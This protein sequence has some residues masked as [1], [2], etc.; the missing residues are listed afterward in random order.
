M[1]TPREKSE[2]KANKNKTPNKTMNSTTN[3]TETSRGRLCDHVDGDIAAQEER[4]VSCPEACSINSMK[5]PGGSS[6]EGL[7]DLI[8]HKTLTNPG[9][10]VAVDSPAQGDTRE[11]S[12]IRRKIQD[13][14]K[15]KK[16][17]WS[18]IGKK[19]GI[20][21]AT[22]NMKGR[23]D[24]RKR[25]K[26]PMV[27][28]RMRKERILVLGLQETHLNEEEAEKL[29]NACPKLIVLSNGKSKNKEGVAF[30][31][32]KDMVKGMQWTHDVLIEGRASKLEIKV[33]DERTMVIILLYA[34]NPE[35]D[36]VE[37]FTKLK[38]K[39][40]HIKN[41]ENII[42]L[43]D[44]NAVEDELD[45]F[46]HREDDKAVMASWKK[47]K[48]KY[49]LVDGW[50]DQNPLSKEY[51][52]T[53]PAS[54]SMSRIDRIYINEQ[55]YPYAHNWSQKTSAKI[56]DHEMVTVDILKKGLPY[57]GEGLWR[58]Y[59]DDI[60]NERTIHKIKRELT[61]TQKAIERK[62]SKKEDGIQKLWLE[63]K[64][65][66]KRIVIAERKKK[67][68]ELNG[69][70]RN[71][72]VTVKEKLK[73]LMEAREEEIEKCRSELE[74]AKKELAS[75]TQDDLKKLQESARARY[76]L[77]GEKCSKYWFNLNKEK[78]PEQTI[79]AM[80]DKSNNI[81]RKTKEMMEI[82]TEYHENL[83]RKPGTSQER[84]EAIEKMKESI[85]GKIPEEICN[86]LKEKTTRREIEAALE[87]T[88]NGTSPGI[89][90]IPY[91]LYK[92]L[93]EEN[94][95]NKTDNNSPDIIKILTMVIN[96]IEE[97]GIIKRK[98]ANET[99]E[100]PEFTDGVMHLIYKKK[101]KEKIENYRPITLL[102]A[103]YKLY[104]KTIAEKLAKAAQAAIH[105][106]QA[107]FVP[108]RSIYDHTKTTQLIIEY[109]EIK[110]VNGCIIALDQEK[111]YDKI[112]H[113]YLWQIL[114]ANGFP[115]T[116]IEKVKEIYKDT[117]KSILV[118]GVKTRQY[119]VERGLHQGDPMSCL[120]YNFAIEPLAN[121]IRASKLKGLEIQN[122][123]RI[124]VN[125]FADDT[126]V[127]LSEE[128]DIQILD[129]IIETFCKASTAK[130]NAEKTE[131]LPIGSEHFRGK[132][133]NER[134]MG[135]NTI[136]EE[137]RIIRD[138]ESMRTLGSWVGNKKSDNIQW[139][140]VI[141]S[142]EKI[143]ETWNKMNLTLRGKELVLKSLVQSKAVY[144][145]TVNGMP[146]VVE[147][148]IRKIYKDFLW[149]GNRAI[150]EWTQII[151]PKEKGGLGIPDIRSRIEAIEIM[152][153]KKWLSP[154]ENKPKWTKIM[155]EI[156][157]SNVAK[158]PLIDE[159]SKMSWALQSWH[160]SE[161]KEAKI[162]KTVKFMLKVARNFN[163]NAVTIKYEKSVKEKIPLWH[164]IL[165]SGANYQWNKKASRCLRNNH[166]IKTIGDLYGQK[167]N[168]NCTKACQEMK[169]RLIRMI[170]EIINPAK[171]TPEKVRKRKLDLT[172]SRLKT[173]AEARN[174]KTFNPDITVRD[175]PLEQVRLFGEKDSSKKRKK[176]IDPLPPAYRINTPDKRT[177]RK[178]TI[179][180]MIKNKGKANEE[181]KTGVTLGKKKMQFTIPNEETIGNARAKAMLWILSKDTKSNLKIKTNDKWLVEW[182]G[183]RITEEEDN[184]WIETKEKNLWKAVLNALRKRDRKIEIRIPEKRSKNDKLL[185][186][187]MELL[188]AKRAKALVVH[189]NNQMPYIRDG[190]KLNSLTQKKAYELTISKN[191]RTPGGIATKRNI[192][193]IKSD[194]RSKWNRNIE[195]REIWNDI[196]KINQPKTREFIWKII[197]GRIKC[198]P[199]F[200]H[201]PKWQEKEF[202]RC[203]K[204]ESIEHILTKCER[205]GQ[206]SL[207]KLIRRVWKKETGIK[208]KKQSIESIMAMGSIKAVNDKGKNVEELYRTMIA[209]AIWTI[210]KNRNKRI[211][212][213][214]KET[215]KTQKRGWIN[216]M[217]DEIKIESTITKINEN[218]RKLKGIKS[219]EDKWLQRETIVKRISK[220]ESKRNIRVLLKAS[221]G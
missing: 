19:Q 179:V 130:F 216:A 205:S 69:S 160:E 212:D 2:I 197:H 48:E 75:R 181:I 49:K 150:M 149:N 121:L 210:W 10:D 84:Q 184:A 79:L 34:P 176:T 171:G 3:K 146:K 137:T 135:P 6:N 153:L 58:M 16:E 94:K 211:F 81:T 157:F 54:G 32:N 85:K 193:A 89:D 67:N 93:M 134:K 31:L 35:K 180:N 62:E 123:V 207:W 196:E 21:I 103:D 219:F 65:E 38:E 88:S 78:M 46:P 136:N 7:D 188:K 8:P 192:E 194:M 63:T 169:L 22:L 51:T 138:G 59:E 43:G 70:K 112:D 42:M 185:K 177:K 109:S 173:N 148:K 127:Y 28:T 41:K 90:G 102:N 118:N 76:R 29:N 141:K 126:L 50:R 151:A 190:A 218:S 114:E 72:R 116:F 74:R 142:Q 198:G 191:M 117:G 25:S 202:C 104:T 125:L 9:S 163:I 87:K 27:A 5:S 158:A 80:R 24:H 107:G 199:F 30:A 204:S 37:F 17:I 18:G 61:T 86:E 66:I 108:K 133:I 115:K 165:M 11:T 110:S 221:T 166:E 106:D 208:M 128:D 203:G 57:I 15:R 77:K 36:K 111:A 120:L 201:I 105:E 156:I 100:N 95:K 12:D 14:D 52:F 13:L 132:V 167:D 122:G 187:E 97:K 215:K 129:K 55:L 145:A 131:Y 174:K 98:E 68:K 26:W 164:N 189:I 214:I 64:D 124:I 209:C 154:N 175:N 4:T 101:E 82:A 155:D 23:N 119:K 162:P 206:K 39:M 56:S 195:E 73:N 217:K 213:G 170:P 99:T 144:L 178:A 53:Q 44:F 83:Q 45:R 71:L 159:K 1:K 91:E 147:E 60:K 20:K 168:D 33:E 186:K 172:P 96:D 161:A 200:R 143:L 47:I 40:K 139:E 183:G 152:W 92:L 140:R 220:G 182:I 113:D